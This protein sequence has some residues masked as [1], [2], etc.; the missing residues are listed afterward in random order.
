MRLVKNKNTGTYSAVIKTL[1]GRTITRSLRTR[2][3]TEA[4]RL[5]KESKL[6]EIEA[7]AKLNALTRDTITA[8]V[9]GKNIKIS[10]VLV[11]YNNF[12]ILK[13][14][15]KHS[16]YSEESVINMFLRQQKLENSGI[17]KITNQHIYDYVN[18]T[19]DNVSVAHKN[20]KLTAIRGLLSY[21]IAN[22]YILKDPSYGV[23]V[24]KSKVSQKK[25][26]KKKA[27]AFTKSDYEKIKR[28]MPYFWSIASDFAYWTGL[29]M[30]DIARLEWDCFDSLSDPQLLIVHTLKTDTR[31]ALPLDDA[32][33]GGGILRDTIA[34]IEPEH[35]KYCFPAWRE[36]A[37]DPKR[38]ATLPTYFSRELKRKHPKAYDEGKRF[39]SFRRSFVTRCKREGKELSEIA[40]WVGH[41]NEKTTELYDVSGSRI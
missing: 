39:H 11:E 8:I 27:V 13:A 37:D 23:A 20:K 30:S 28:H 21:A 29:R 26:E 16:I 17:S 25:K 18:D 40:V 34:R 12:R 19:N 5:I 15:S 4:K 7:A 38:R 41:A 1:S 31:V 2:D 32:L 10:Q 9:A 33:I 6:E 22:A 14:H 35:E 24:D 3:K 36:L